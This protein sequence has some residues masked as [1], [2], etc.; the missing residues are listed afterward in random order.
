MADIYVRYPYD[1][2]GKNPD[3]LVSGELH[4]LPVVSGF[5]YK[6]IT[7]D[8]GGFY[9]KTCRVYDSNYNPLT[10]NVDYVLTYRY[11]HL[12]Q[13]LGL[14]IVNDI[15]F[16]D[17]SR[18]GS[19]YVSAQIVG[20]DV[21]FSLTGITDYVEWY[22]RQEAGY[23]PRMFDY[24]GNEP[25]WKPGELDKERWRLDTFQPFNNEIYQLSRAVEGGR[26]ISEDKFRKDILDEY[27]AF[28][29]MFND[30]LQ[31]HIDDKDNPHDTDKS[32]V[33]LDLLQNFDLAT[34]EQSNQ[35]VSNTRYQ[36]PELSWATLNTNALAPLN[37]HIGNTRN[38]HQTTPDK[39]DA[40][41]KAVVD[42][43]IATKYFNN[44]TVANTNLFVD[45]TTSFTYTQYFNHVRNNIPATNFVS[46]TD[47]GYLSP[48]RLGLGNPSAT[49]VLRSGPTPMWQSIDLLIMEA[50]PKISPGLLI[51]AYPAGTTPT[52]AFNNA[53]QDPWAYTASIGSIICY[54]LTD[55]YTWGAGNGALV[56]ENSVLYVAYKSANGWV[57]I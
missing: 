5:P 27:N 10:E 42:N 26:G 40:P 18:V 55:S 43:T 19:V 22:N 13:M 34:V 29:D 12:S 37:Q 7:M 4:P 24:N 16:L 25:V 20:G 17:Q 14:E 50:E 32:H 21:A 33:K 56:K 39:I 3:N 30:R 38:P 31:N 6:I 1:P 52:N 9:A 49:T 48:Y 2:T 11:A 51:K 36:T 45:G 15:V 46:G 53:I 47:E 8:N 54:R 44:E 35:G 28:L 41:T 57:Q 23:I